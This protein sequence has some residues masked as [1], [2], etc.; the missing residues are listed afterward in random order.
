[1]WLLHPAVQRD[2]HVDGALLAAQH[3]VEQGTHARPDRRDPAERRQ[4]LLQHRVVGEG[5]VLGFR[6]QEEVERV[7]RRHVGDEIDGDVEMRDALGEHDAGEVVAL[8]VLLP[9]EEMRLRLDLQRIGQDRACAR[10]A[11]AAAGWSAGRAYT[12][13]S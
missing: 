4:F 12:S 10:A 1:M 7:D 6:F 9:V 2:Q 13:R 8:R 11:P 5:P 3:A